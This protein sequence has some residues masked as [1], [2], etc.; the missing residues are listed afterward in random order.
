MDD[1][2]INELLLILKGNTGFLH[3]I[4]W[5]HIKAFKE[6]IAENKKLKETKNKFMDKHYSCEAVIT[7]LVELK[8]YKDKFGKDEKYLERQPIAWNRARRLIGK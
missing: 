6:L 4:K 7:M 1:K 5:D 2:L 8:E 3:E